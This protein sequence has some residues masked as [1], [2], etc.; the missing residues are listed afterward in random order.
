MWN[1]GLRGQDD[2]GAEVEMGRTDEKAG[3]THEVVPGW[4]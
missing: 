2:N 3:G 4:K 1:E